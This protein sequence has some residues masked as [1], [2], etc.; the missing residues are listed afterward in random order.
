MIQAK[1]IINN[2]EVSGERKSFRES[3][4][5]TEKKVTEYYHANK[6]N[7]RE[8]I[9][10]AREAFDKNFNNWVTDYKL[11]ERVLRKIAENIMENSQT[12]IDSLIEELGMPL[13]QARSHVIASADI[14]NYY[15]GLAGKIYGTS[16]FLNNED[17]INIVKEPVGVV[18]AITPW[19]FPLTQSAR[20]LAPSL[21]VG[22]TVV[23]KPASYTSGISYELAKLIIKSG[24]PRGVFHMVLGSGEEI[25]KE[26]VMN[27]N[28]DKV[29]FTGE[30]STG[31]WIMREAS[32]N[33]KRVSLELGG[34]NPFILFADSDLEKSIRSLMFGMFR[35]AGQAC[36]ST[37][38]L[39]MEESLKEKALPLILSAVKSLKVGLPSEETTDVGPLVSKS[40]EEKVLSYIKYGKENNYKIIAG[41][42]KIRDEPLNRGYFIEPTVFDDVDYKSK[43]AQEEIFGPV[44]A[45]IYFKDEEEAI[46]IA[47]AIDYGLTASIWINN[48]KRALRISRRIR[49]GT[50]W[51]NDS[52]TQPVEGLWG[53]YKQS[54]LGR[55]LGLQGLEE[56]LEYKMLYISSNDKYSHYSQVVK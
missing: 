10:Y 53:G 52:Y 37:S 7:V 49:A 48:I 51:I 13:R 4:Y 31:K 19:N 8:A 25:G 23:W 15:S 44:L 43:I 20:K 11:R 32:S 29:S 26:I 41:G 34:K 1:S 40:Q 24:I 50:V 46:R 55:E 47:N 12:L 5:D 42:N 14:F 3:P 16:L 36:G 6:E 2:Q 54:G 21:A 45:I 35:N 18:G 28:I 22:C 33:L 9:D 38:R 30:T 17:L 56:F 27:S 39:I